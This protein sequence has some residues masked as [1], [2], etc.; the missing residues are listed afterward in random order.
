MS[1]ITMQDSISVGGGQESYAD[2]TEFDEPCALCLE[3]GE[4]FRAHQPGTD[5]D[6]EM[7]PILDDLAFGNPLKE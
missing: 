5:P 4:A 1:C 2:R 6:V 7:D 3:C